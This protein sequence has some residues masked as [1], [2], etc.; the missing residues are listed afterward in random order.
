M[1][2]G[3][4]KGIGLRKDRGTPI[5]I[6]QDML[7]GLMPAR[8]PSLFDENDPQ[9]E[10]DADAEADADLKSGRVISHEAMKAWLFSWGT[11]DELPPPKVGD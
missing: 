5:Q 6:A 8:E 4:A 2:V 7:D 1:K 9:A 3:P 10:E 11:P